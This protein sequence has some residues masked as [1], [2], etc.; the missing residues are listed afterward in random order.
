MEGILAITF[1]F[2]GGTLFLLSISPV[3]KAI[4]E[5]IRAQGAV[6]MQ[7]PELLHE[8]DALR[9]DVAE[10]QERVDF[11]ERLLAQQ[12]E[13]PQVASGEARVM[14]QAR[15][16]LP[17]PPD[18]P[19]D[20]NLIFMS[21]GGPPAIVMI[22]CLSLLAAT[23]SSGRS[24]GR[25]P[26]ASRGRAPPIPRCA[27]R[28]SSCSTAWAR[29]TPSRAGGRAGGA[30]RFRRAAADA[31]PGT[32][33]RRAGRPAVTAARCRRRCPAQP[34]PPG[35]RGGGHRRRSRLGSRSCSCCA[36]RCL[37]VV[38]LWPLIQAVARRIEAGA[39]TPRR[40]RSSTRC[41][42]GPAA[43]GVAARMAELEERLDF[44]ERLL[45]QSASRPLRLGS[46]GSETTRGE[47]CTNCHRSTWRSLIAFAI[48]IAE[49]L[50]RPARRRLR[51]PDRGRR[52]AVGRPAGSLATWSSCGRGWPRWRSG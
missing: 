18:P 20:P 27:R 31:G 11:T 42:S 45:A 48:G 47:R 52:A 29:W 10:L 38:L 46:A 43:R 6:P 40:R 16:R 35:Q 9:R 13:R 24:C 3:G 26:A 17:P 32:G 14:I 50:H 7:D 33:R 15:S 28:S 21:D 22:V 8:V 19:F 4:A 49:D 41:R 23:S 36:W 2:G 44:A 1:I 37:V 12:Q 51:R 39:S 30:A 34:P 25:W 5:R